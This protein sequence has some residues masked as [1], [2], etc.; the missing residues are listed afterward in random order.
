MGEVIT[1]DKNCTLTL[2]KVLSAYNYISVTTHLLKCLYTSPK[3]NN[4]SQ[5]MLLLNTLICFLVAC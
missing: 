1:V 2:K 4:F 5:F 3:I